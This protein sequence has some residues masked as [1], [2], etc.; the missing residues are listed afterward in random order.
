MSLS[1]PP[2]SSVLSSHS[3][4]SLAST[5]GTEVR[6]V[7][8]N[9]RG[10]SRSLRSTLLTVASPVIHLLSPHGPRLARFASARGTS[11]ESDEGRKKRG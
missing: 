8:E 2:P 5:D 3:L 4:C 7:R 9:D 11:V 6:R 1:F 10:D